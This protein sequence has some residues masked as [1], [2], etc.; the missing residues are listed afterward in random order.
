MADI[1]QVARCAGV[2]IATVSRVLNNSG[3]VSEKS[4]K[5]VYDAV[6]ALDYK[7]NNLARN[8]R[9]R[10]SGSVIMI[11]NDIRNP[12][13][14]PVVR[15]M[16]D[17]T[18]RMGYSLLIGNADN[19]PDKVLHYLNDVTMHKAD[20]V[21]LMTPCCP[22][23][24]LTAFAKSIP[25]VLLNTH[26]GY[27]IPSISIDDTAAFACL[28]EHLIQLGHRDIAFF[29]ARRMGLMETRLQG[30]QNVLEKYGIPF[31]PELVLH[32]GNTAMTNGYDGMACLLQ[33][34]ERPTA[35]MAYNDQ[36]A[37]GALKC[38]K[39]H[40]VRVPE[41]MSIT[42]FDDIIFSTAV[43]PAL[44]TIHQPAYEMGKAAAELL[45]DVLNGNTGVRH[46]QLQQW[47]LI[48]R[49]STAPACR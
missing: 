48:I 11:C 34:G 18:A 23:D 47:E 40:G 33:R 22:G 46:T 35:V 36:I 38:A 5:K 7:R 42:G 25:M 30:Y 37:I 6:Q 28:T 14:P 19:S 13:L 24:K 3:P 27:D 39:E 26:L 17:A 4:R 20:G 15:G 44:T 41:E 29:A 8:F 45:F 9:M 43:E 21:I 2:S 16:E 32:T 12:F 1:K 49:E 31:R 10:R